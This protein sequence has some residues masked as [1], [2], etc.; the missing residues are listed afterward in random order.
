VSQENYSLSF[1]AGSVHRVL[2]WR[3]TYS[4][5]NFPPGD[6]QGMQA[7][8]QGLNQQIIQLEARLSRLAAGRSKT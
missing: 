3:A 5:F 2:R 1:L 4:K 8:A 7:Q 6:Q